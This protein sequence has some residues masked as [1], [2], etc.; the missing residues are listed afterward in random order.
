MLY[1]KLDVEGK[2]SLD[3]YLFSAT[4]TDREILLYEFKKIK[5]L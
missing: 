3:F 1:F 2:E 4:R 5:L